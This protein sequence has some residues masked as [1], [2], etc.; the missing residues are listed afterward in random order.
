M[1]FPAHRGAPHLGHLESERVHQH[2]LSQHLSDAS[3]GCDR[4]GAR[5]FRTGC[6]AS[7]I[8]KG[9]D[10]ML[11]NLTASGRHVDLSAEHDSDGRLIG[12]WHIDNR[13]HDEVA[14]E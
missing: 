11:S 5:G 13:Y 7:G 6:G 12:F 14:G 1:S 2:P 9:M 10:I 3:S 8:L 4:R